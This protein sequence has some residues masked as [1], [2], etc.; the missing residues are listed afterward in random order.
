MF[1]KYDCDRSG[2]LEKNEA[3]E[4]IKSLGKW[5]QDK[6]YYNHGPFEVRRPLKLFYVLPWKVEFDIV[7]TKITHCSQVMGLV[8]KP[9]LSCLIALLLKEST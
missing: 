5:Y 4:A 1:F 9:L 2:A 7:K 6:Y 8:K 3:H